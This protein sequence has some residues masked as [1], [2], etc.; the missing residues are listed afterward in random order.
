MGRNTSITTVSR[1]MCEHTEVS[2][3]AQTFG[4][5]GVTSQAQGLFSGSLEDCPAA[6]LFI[7]MLL[8]GDPP[9]AQAPGLSRLCDPA[10]FTA[11][12]S[13]GASLRVGELQIER[14]LLADTTCQQCQAQAPPRGA[15]RSAREGVS[16]HPWWRQAGRI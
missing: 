16:V 15:P 11:R 2:H 8:S 6:A 9:V 3:P 12:S 13:W 14:F 10:V 4:I 7:T 5:P 1:P